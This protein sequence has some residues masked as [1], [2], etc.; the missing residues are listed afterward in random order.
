MAAP[1]SA[2]NKYV[3]PHL[4][5]GASASS[6]PARF[7]NGSSQPSRQQ[8]DS[9]ASRQTNDHS[10]HNSR[11]SRPEVTIPTTPCGQGDRKN[12]K[13]NIKVYHRVVSS[14]TQLA[15][16]THMEYCWKALVFTDPEYTKPYDHRESA[17]MEFQTSFFVTQNMFDDLAAIAAGARNDDTCPW[18]EQLR[19]GRGFVPGQAHTGHFDYDVMRSRLPG[20]MQQILDKFQS[21]EILADGKQYCLRPSREQEFEGEDVSR[22][23][24]ISHVLD[25]FKNKDKKINLVTKFEFVL[26]DGDQRD[27]FWGLQ[28]KK[29]AVHSHVPQ[30]YHRRRIEL[31]VHVYPVDV[32]VDALETEV[33][34]NSQQFGE[35]WA[36]HHKK[37]HQ[38]LFE[39]R[40]IDLLDSI[41]ALPVA[42]LE[43]LCYKERTSFYS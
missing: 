34:S 9:N 6:P 30:Q 23:F 21:Q 11:F 43:A 31:N 28:N 2:S 1:S 38:V 15:E 8:S 16:R 22:A 20:D 37:W 18:F 40:H 25:T 39:D 5:G 4:R 29:N 42:A 32:D 14:K 12:F 26:C 3:P 35:L 24:A 13:A 33:A 27:V 19:P 41:D 10:I 17:Y 36:E 7:G